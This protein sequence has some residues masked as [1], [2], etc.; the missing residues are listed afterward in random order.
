MKHWT[1]R[2]KWD[3]VVD[4]LLKAGAEDKVG[5]LPRVGVGWMSQEMGQVDPGGEENEVS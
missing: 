4:W 1:S 2:V 5:L 3:V